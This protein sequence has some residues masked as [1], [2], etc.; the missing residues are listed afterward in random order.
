M[1]EYRQVD[2]LEA[3]YAWETGV[4]RRNVRA[5]RRTFYMPAGATARARCPKT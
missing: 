3:G 5:R 1:R 2:H 4:E